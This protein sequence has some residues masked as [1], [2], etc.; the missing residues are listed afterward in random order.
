MKDHA[1]INTSVPDKISAAR[2]VSSKLHQLLANSPSLTF[3]TI[4]KSDLDNFPHAAKDKQ[5]PILHE[6]LSTCMPV[7]PHQQRI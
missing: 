6:P 3:E 5:S 1:C 4:R 2:H 7:G